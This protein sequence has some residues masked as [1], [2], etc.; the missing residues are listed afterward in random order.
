M[1]YKC[2]LR[3]AHNLDKVDTLAEQKERLLAT[4]HITSNNLN[5]YCVE[6]LFRLHIG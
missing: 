4:K 3:T 5:N 6:A 2:T 1:N